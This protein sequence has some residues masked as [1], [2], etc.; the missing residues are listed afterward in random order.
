MTRLR[1][2][3]SHLWNNKGETIDT[4]LE[5]TVRG[6]ELSKDTITAAAPVPGLGPALD[7]AIELLRKVQVCA[8]CKCLTLP[9]VIRICDTGLA[10]ELRGP[11][12]A[13]RRD[14]GPC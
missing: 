10:V 9:G 3:L 12:V 2:R 6:L 8:R 5:V 11:E 13:V 14:D 7:L 1:Q 4:V